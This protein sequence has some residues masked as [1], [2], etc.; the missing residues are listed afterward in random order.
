MNPFRFLIGARGVQD[1]R[2]LVEGARAA[3]GI[4]CSDLTSTTTWRRSRPRSRCSR[5]WRWRPSASGC[6]RSCSTTTC[7]IRRC[8]PRSSPAWTSSAAGA[9]VVG[10]G[11]GWNEPEY[12]ATGL[13]YDPPATRIE[14]LTEAIAILR[15]LFARRR[16][17][18]R[19]PVL[20][21]HGA[22]RAAEAGPEAASAVP[23]RRDE[24]AGRPAGGPG[25]RHR[26]ARPAPGRRGDPGRLR[27][28]DRRPGR[29]GPGGSR[30]AVSSSLDLSV[31]RLVGDITITDEPLKVAAEVARQLERRGRASRSPPQDVLESP[32]SL[33]G[34]VPDLV[35]KLARI[36]QRWGINSFL[37]GWFD[38]PRL[39]DIAPVVEQL[40]GT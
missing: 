3:E 2:T 7:A 25:G 12:R 37:I 26:R 16:V 8:W 4:G 11:A 14:R 19:G 36:R 32:Y 15:G 28:A 24:G 9:L 38:E 35:D 22:R 17:Q 30:R 33:I 21:D 39:R 5:P 13:V 29:L 6:V 18:L 31:L 27:G 1:R 40:A 34:T 23:H 10:I 20:H